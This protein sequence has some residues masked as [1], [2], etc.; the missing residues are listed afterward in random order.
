MSPV[1][2]G[3]CLPDW[4]AG[5]P[6][7][8]LLV[9]TDGL[10]VTPCI[11]CTSVFFCRVLGAGLQ[12][13]WACVHKRLVSAEMTSKCPNVGFWLSLKVRFA[14]FSLIILRR[15]GFVVEPVSKPPLTVKCNAA[16]A[17]QTNAGKDSTVEHSANIN[18]LERFLCECAFQSSSGQ[19]VT[20]VSPPP[21]VVSAHSASPPVSAVFSVSLFAVNSYCFFGDGFKLSEGRI[22]RVFLSNQSEFKSSGFE[23][24]SQEIQKN[25]SWFGS[26]RLWKS[27][28][29]CLQQQK[30]LPLTFMRNCS[31]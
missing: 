7:L 17:R 19:S 14:S 11:F 4:T 28:G 20:G 25:Y 29:R 5:S 23:K 31:W 18:N 10:R 27:S 2:T 16:A 15:F 26:F 12:Q 24:V 8:S 6:S 22:D 13:V 1:E 30:K 21:R 9:Q 3:P